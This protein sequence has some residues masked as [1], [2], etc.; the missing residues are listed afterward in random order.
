[1]FQFYHSSFVPT[2]TGRPLLLFL[3]LSLG[4]DR[5]KSALMALGLKCGGT[6]EERAKRLFATKGK[7]L[8]ELDPSLFAKKSSKGGAEGKARAQ[9]KLKEV[10]SMEAQVYKFAEMLAE[11]RTATKE[12]VERKQ[13]SKREKENWRLF[14]T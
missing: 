13:A 10:A 6:L 12:N 4:P 9:E 7:S 2:A 1:M 8:N 11:Q 14:T 3:P 5:L